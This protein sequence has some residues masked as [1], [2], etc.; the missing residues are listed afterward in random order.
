MTG[1]PSYYGLGWGVDYDER[2]RVFWAHAGAFSLGARTQVNLLPAANL[3]IVV[4]ANAFPTGVPDGLTAGFYDLVLNGA[5]TRDWI[6][7]WNKSYDALFQSFGASA[8][9]YATPPAQPSP[10]LPVG[11]YIGTYAN[12]YF[13]S[14][15]VVDASGSLTLRIGPEQRSFPLRHWARDVFTYVPD[16]EP[17]AA[18][19]G[20]TFW[21]GPDQTARQVVLEDMNDAGQG[22]FARVAPPA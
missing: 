4:L 9:E 20:V 8:A 3:G 2:G 19:Y 6:A 1:G 10:A 5:L 16:P 11:T 12:D 7:F 13:G 18:P 14:I 22:T 21:V 17:P 15:E